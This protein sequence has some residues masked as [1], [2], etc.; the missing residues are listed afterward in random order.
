MEESSVAWWKIARRLT[1]RKVDYR[2]TC[3]T[4]TKPCVARRNKLQKTRNKTKKRTEKK[5]E[6]KK[7]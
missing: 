1:R 2:D 3:K 7:N 6:S 4:K 5:Q